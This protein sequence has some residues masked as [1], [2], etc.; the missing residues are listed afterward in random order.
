M[1]VPSPEPDWYE[2]YPIGVNT[3]AGHVMDVQHPPPI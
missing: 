1:A 3:P 2:P